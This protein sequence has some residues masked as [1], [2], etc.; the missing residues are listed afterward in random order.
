[1]GPPTTRGAYV[2]EHEAE[3]TARLSEYTTR[4]VAVAPRFRS[5]PGLA[6]DLVSEA[7]G[8][9][10]QALNDLLV[11]AADTEGFIQ[12][13]QELGAFT[14]TDDEHQRLTWEKMPRSR[15][16]AYRRQGYVPVDERPEPMAMGLGRF[17]EVPFVSDALETAW[18]LTGG[19]LVSVAGDT[20]NLLTDVANVPGTV[21]R[22]ART[23]ALTAA[24]GNES[25]LNPATWV[26]AWRRSWH[27]ERVFD[28][29]RANKV[30]ELFE[31]EE[32]Y[33]YAVRLASGETVDDIAKGFGDP[34]TPAY[35]NA[36]A[37]VQE[38]ALHPLTQQ[39]VR[40]LGH[41]KISPG[42]DLARGLGLE[43]GSTEYSMLSGAA[44]FAWTWFTDPTLV[45]GKARKAVLFRKYGLAAMKGGDVV[46]RVRSFYGADMVARAGE[47]EVTDVLDPKY[48]ETVHGARLS[49]PERAAVVI[50]DHVHQGQLRRLQ[51]AMPATSSLLPTLA[52]YHRAGHGR[53]RHAG[54]VARFFER[55]VGLTALVDGRYARY[56]GGYA[57]LPRLTRTGVSRVQ[58]KV[59]WDDTIDFMDDAPVRMR[60]ALEADDVVGGTD[61][62][63]TLLQLDHVAGA[64]KKLTTLIPHRGY[65]AFNDKTTPETLS[66]LLDFGVTGEQ[67]FALFD[68]FLLAETDQ[69]R[70]NVV[71][72]A[73]RTIFANIGILDDE[74]YA[75]L[76]NRWL[77]TGM[78]RFALDDLDQV[79][80]DGVVAHSGI[81]EIDR[82]QAVAIPDFREISA[83][84][85][86]DRFTKFVT[87]MTNSRFAEWFM[88]YWRPAVILRPAF[89]LR[90]GGEEML[91]QFARFGLFHPVK[92][93]VAMP[94]G[95]KADDTPLWVTG[96]LH[97]GADAIFGRAARS[98]RYGS[99]VIGALASTIHGGLVGLVDGVED[100][101][102]PAVTLA[103]RAARLSLDRYDLAAARDLRL[104]SAARRAEVQAR[105][106]ELG[107]PLTPREFRELAEMDFVQRAFAQVGGADIGVQG[108]LSHAD[109]PTFYLDAGTADT[110]L[111]IPLRPDPDNLYG[112]YVIRGPGRDE[113]ALPM[114]GNTVGR[115]QHSPVAKA[116]V[117]ARQMR[118]GQAQADRIVAALPSALTGAG[119]LE[120]VAAARRAM[121]G[122]Y[123]SIR[124]RI[125]KWLDE[126]DETQMN[127]ALDRMAPGPLRDVV[128]SFREPDR[129]KPEDIHALMVDSRG[130]ERELALLLGGDD[131]DRWRPLFEAAQRGDGAAADELEEMVAYHRMRQADVADDYRNLD[132]NLRHSSIDITED[133]RM[134]IAR[135]RER[136]DP[137]TW[138]SADPAV[139]LAAIRSLL[140]E[141]EAKVLDEI[142]AMGEDFVPGIF[143]DPELSA[144]L[145]ARQMGATGD[146][147]DDLIDHQMMA[148]AR[149]SDML[150]ANLQ[151]ILER[152]DETAALPALDDN[153]RENA[154]VLRR[155]L[156]LELRSDVGEDLHEMLRPLADGKFT[157]AGHVDRADLARLPSKIHGPKL[158]PAPGAT[159]T[160]RV[161]RWGFT[162]LGRQISAIARRPLWHRLYADALH[163]AEVILGPTLRNKHLATAAQ[164]YVGDLERASDALWE[165]TIQLPAARRAI[166]AEAL[167][168]L[169]VV[170]ALAAAKVDLVASPR[171]ADVVRRWWLN[172]SR[173][174]GE[175]SRVAMQRATA[176]M[177]PFIDDH[178]IRSQF[179]EN[180]R[181]LFPFWFAQEA[182]YKRW[183]RTLKA[184][185]EALRRVQLAHHALQANGWV[186]RNEYGEEVFVYPGAEFVTGA[187]ARAAELL[188]PGGEAFTLPIAAPLTGQLRYAAPGLDAATGGVRDLLPQ[189]GPLV[190]LSLSA[191][192]R[193]DPEIGEPLEETVLGPR[194]A[195]R[196][197]ADIFIPTTVMRFWKAATADDEALA[198]ATIG[199]LQMLEAADAA[200]RRRTDPDG[201]GPLEGEGFGLVPGAGATPHEIEVYLDRVRHW[202]RI[203]LI[204]KGVVGALG[205]ASPAVDLDPDQLSPEYI[206]LLQSGMPIEEATRRFLSEHPDATAFTI[207]G[208]SSPSGNTD[209]DPTEAT[210]E[211]LIDNQGYFE[212]YR[213]AAPWLVPSGTDQGFD[214]KAWDTMFALHVRERRGLDEFYDELKFRE[215]APFFFEQQT[216]K[217]LALSRAKG[218]GP[219]R[220]AIEERWRAWR[221]DYLAQHPVFAERYRNP[222]GA[223]RR[224]KVLE[225]IDEALA[226]P[227]RPE[228]PHGEM[229]T[230]LVASWHRLE[231]AIET[232]AADRSE[233]GV[234]ERLRL[235]TSFAGWAEAYTA[236]HPTVSAFYRRILEPE[237]DLPPEV[238][239]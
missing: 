123:Q 210:W 228:T 91:A 186:E 139:D 158:V 88:N 211:F 109:D 62:A 212:E 236:A 122:L 73:Y 105:A 126:G 67:R 11:D 157:Y 53:I 85:R 209:V 86:R 59:A 121:S 110:P 107:R 38:F 40:E 152:L 143:D 117:R 232:I 233:R 41:A 30:A 176:D 133:Q 223:E 189:A 142:E 182:F 46:K 43:P 58:L 161:V 72:D 177:V 102:Q 26:D 162:H 6:Y 108:V 83:A 163:E 99:T 31:D 229:L 137:E 101:A 15:Q 96:Q 124:R 45:A 56:L 63:I 217:D 207:F 10:V 144:A 29:R 156:D 81:L 113:L 132:R 136:S 16:Q 54:D 197:I 36:Y 203:L 89:A 239:D 205:P 32:A 231:G 39:A 185:P 34:G 66:R 159:R 120:D 97:A 55:S 44:D 167:S 192:R 94:L 198:S 214:H 47:R 52:E 151:A 170:N 135:L 33:E 17:G 169:E 219:R 183:G 128:A 226:D 114:Y 213:H 115:L 111:V 148:N 79:E 18:D 20:M 178:K 104:P 171:A 237:L 195:R 75:P 103:R 175:L 180:A 95:A 69:A 168:E 199:A 234:A 208:S 22:M 220:R 202:A 84:M 174:R 8:R 196:S 227:T 238:D 76:V 140:G 164:A 92:Q 82:A 204:T 222:A 187:I 4:L 87:G 74:A 194:G 80:I 145:S 153:L 49:G 65:L 150:D 28:T 60:R 7:E 51:R 24:G 118:M 48:W 64:A 68:Q 116:V 154:R 172:E 9:G 5:V 216:R 35:G 131:A 1:M 179:S 70:R 19:Q 149:R 215:A 201:D 119:S 125:L 188:W 3:R 77:N 130:V 42:R 71:R 225:E 181:N 218:N 190:A 112:E 191:L 224:R 100:V 50:A 21:Y 27:G 2:E 160:E 98:E 23:D 221:D 93:W 235:R 147:I 166:G 146:A 206:S 141:N 127:E 200:E 25:T 78:H 193:L 165:A 134:A 13:R 106:A 129:W 61:T 12:L 184:S 155:K 173:V 57:A 37:Q 90:A 230:E 138:A 14:G